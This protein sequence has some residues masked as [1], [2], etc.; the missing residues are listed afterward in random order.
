[1][2][3]VHALHVAAFQSVLNVPSAQSAQVLS[4]VGP[5]EATTYCPGPHA[6]HAEQ[7]VALAVTL[8]VP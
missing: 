4:E 3:V 7:V 2:Q 5:P 1:M 8:N 6:I